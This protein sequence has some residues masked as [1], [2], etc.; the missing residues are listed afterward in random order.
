[1]L[2]GLDLT[3]DMTELLRIPEGWGGVALSGFLY[4]SDALGNAEDSGMI[5][6]EFFGGMS[7]GWSF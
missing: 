2:W 1:M 7:I 5:Q 3:Y 4:F 6:D